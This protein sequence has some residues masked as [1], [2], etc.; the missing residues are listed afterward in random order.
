MRH[1]DGSLVLRSAGK[2]QVSLTPSE[3]I[4]AARW[5]QSS[6]SDYFDYRLRPETAQELQKRLQELADW[7]ATEAVSDPQQGE[8]YCL[9]LFLSPESL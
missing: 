2:G 3:T 7:L 6:F 8:N 9:A 5:P 1:S 4:S